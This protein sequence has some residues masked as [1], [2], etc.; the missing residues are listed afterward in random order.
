MLLF[1]LFLL[2]LVFL[3][4]LPFLVFLVLPSIAV[5]FA[6]FS[7]L[8]H[9]EECS[10]AEKRVMMASARKRQSLVTT[11]DHRISGKFPLVLLWFL[12]FFVIERY[13]SL[14]RREQSREKKR[15]KKKHALEQSKPDIFTIHSSW[16]SS[17]NDI[18]KEEKGQ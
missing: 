13:L 6:F 10:A 17:R 9:C 7:W 4:F 12:S 1:L 2:F 14:P 16:Q 8:V 3:L 15:E 5:I 11:K 18:S